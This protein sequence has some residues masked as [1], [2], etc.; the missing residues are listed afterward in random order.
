MQ[1]RNLQQLQVALHSE[2]GWIPKNVVRRHMRLV[3]PFYDAVIASGE[4]FVRFV[5]N[6]HQ[7]S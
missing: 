3:Q 6:L 1:P 4:G 7:D 5:K 2:W